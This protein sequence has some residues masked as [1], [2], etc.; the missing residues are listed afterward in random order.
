MKVLKF[1]ERFRKLRVKIVD[2][3]GKIL[4]ELTLG[5]KEKIYVELENERIILINS[6]GELKII[7]YDIAEK[8]LNSM[9]GA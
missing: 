1:K 3:E 7:K 4:Q 9:G 6:N 5:N 8:Y 2:N